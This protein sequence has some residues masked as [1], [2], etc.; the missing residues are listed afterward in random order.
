MVTVVTKV[1]QKNNNLKETKLNL[2][3]K[4]FKKSAVCIVLLRYFC[5]NVGLQ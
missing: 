1:T 4:V 2:S 5:S 3:N